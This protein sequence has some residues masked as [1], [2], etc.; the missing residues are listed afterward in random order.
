ML[1]ELCKRKL[2]GGAK[3]VVI[4]CPKRL[5]KRALLVI[6]IPPTASHARIEQASLDRAGRLPT[7]SGGRIGEGPRAG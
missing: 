1:V 3:L 6:D 2:D 4:G 7:P 5:E